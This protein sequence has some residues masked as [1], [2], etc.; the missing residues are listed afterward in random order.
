VEDLRDLDALFGRLRKGDEEARTEAVS[1]LAGDM[2]RLAPLVHRRCEE[3]DEA[4][5]SRVAGRVM[6]V[7]EAAAARIDTEL[8]AGE[9]GGRMDS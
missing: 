3:P 5:A 8:A 6:A 9:R 7:Y 4:W 2:I 1:V